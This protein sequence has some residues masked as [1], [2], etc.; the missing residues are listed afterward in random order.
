MNGQ[1]LDIIAS[2]ELLGNYIHGWI[3]SLVEDYEVNE[4]NQ[5]YVI[6]E[7]KELLYAIERNKEGA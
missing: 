7:I 1:S 4:N 3:E 6:G 2:K 5:T